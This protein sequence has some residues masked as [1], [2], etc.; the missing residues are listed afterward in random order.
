MDEVLDLELLLR[1]ELAENVDFFHYFRNDAAVANVTLTDDRVECFPIKLEAN[2]PR[3]DPNIGSSFGVIEHR[4]L[5]K[6]F[7][8]SNGLNIKILIINPPIAMQLALID[9]K[10]LVALIALLD[11]NHANIIDFLRHGADQL[12]GIF[13]VEVFEQEQR[14]ESEENSVVH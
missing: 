1:L 7:P 11:D 14:F 13:V 5:P 9:N 2:S 6:H 4:N 12:A 8:L 10:D 3:L